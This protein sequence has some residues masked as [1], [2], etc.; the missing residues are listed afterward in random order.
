MVNVEIRTFHHWKCRS[1]VVERAHVGPRRLQLGRSGTIS[2]GSGTI[3]AGSGPRLAPYSPSLDLDW[4]RPSPA[5]RPLHMAPEKL[6]ESEGNGCKKKNCPMAASRLMLVW[7][8]GKG[9][10]YPTKKITVVGWRNK[11]YF[12]S[13]NG[14]VLSVLVLMTMT[15]GKFKPP[16]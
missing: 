5:L 16:S 11:L 8:P 13:K 2:A 4:H 7:S 1:V 6:A 12:F 15:M 10:E 3:S 9:S 14:V